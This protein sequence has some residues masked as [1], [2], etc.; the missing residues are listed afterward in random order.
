MAK[1]ELRGSHGPAP[2]HVLTR[3]I[4]IE[5]LADLAVYEKQGGY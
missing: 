2:D 1:T 5:N 4:G 3:W